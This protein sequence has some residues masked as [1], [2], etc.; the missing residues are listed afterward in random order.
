MTLT[1]HSG[2]AAGADTAFTIA[3]FSKGFNVFTHSFIGHNIN[4]SVFKKSTIV[5]HKNDELRENI[6]IMTHVS[7]LLNRQ[8]SNKQYVQNLILRNYFQVSNS[9]LIVAVATI[10]DMEKVL[11]SGGTGY[12][13]KLANIQLKS[14][15]VFCQKR[16]EWFYSLNGSILNCLN[17]TPDISKFPKSWAGIG[18]RDLTTEGEKS[19]YALFK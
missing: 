12:A 17:R 19:I 7:G 5:K 14:V 13:V 16:K 2:G 6:D 15:L 3:G 11:I 4:N 8:F 18:S 10:D 1:I 9:D